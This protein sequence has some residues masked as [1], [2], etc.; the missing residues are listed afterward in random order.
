MPASIGTFNEGSYAAWFFV[1]GPSL[2][3]WLDIRGQVDDEDGYEENTHE[4]CMGSYV[5]FEPDESEGVPLKRG[6]L[7]LYGMLD[8]GE[9]RQGDA[10]CFDSAENLAN[11]LEVLPW[12]T[13]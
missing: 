7:S 9:P 10:F 11:A 6:Y 1:V 13:S 4:M 12:T 3:P 2:T 8:D 5:R